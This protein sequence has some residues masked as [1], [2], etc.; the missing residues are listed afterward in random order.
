MGNGCERDEQTNF[1]VDPRFFQNRFFSIN[2]YDLYQF[3]GILDRLR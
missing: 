1:Y 3:N 2:E